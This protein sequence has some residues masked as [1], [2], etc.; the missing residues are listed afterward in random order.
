MRRV[1]E[2]RK[3]VQAV[4][5]LNLLLQHLQER[6]SSTVFLPVIVN[7]MVLGPY[8]IALPYLTQNQARAGDR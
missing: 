2:E 5:A 1:Y 6:D 3:I 7:H 8:A 4:G